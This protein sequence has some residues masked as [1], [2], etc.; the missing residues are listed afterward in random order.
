MVRRKR[1]LTSGRTHALC[2]RFDR[3]TRC[4]RASALRPATPPQLW[5]RVSRLQC[6]MSR[7][8]HNASLALGQAV[9][10]VQSARTGRA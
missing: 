2:P 1:A 5:P 9:K 4:D 10:R 3:R 7:G 6:C 8:A